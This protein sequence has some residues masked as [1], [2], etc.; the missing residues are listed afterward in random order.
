MLR[1]SAACGL[2][3]EMPPS[4][5]TSGT[6]Y[7]VTSCSIAACGSPS[8]EDPLPPPKSLPRKPIGPL[9]IQMAADGARSPGCDQSERRSRGVYSASAQPRLGVPPAMHILVTGASGFIGRHVVAE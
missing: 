1:T 2:V 3:G 8:D 4:A 9:P 5:F 6:S 7:S